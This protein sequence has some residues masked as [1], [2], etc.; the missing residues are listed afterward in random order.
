MHRRR[1]ELVDNALEFF[2]SNGKTVFLSFTDPKVDDIGLSLWQ[3]IF[4]AKE[5]NIYFN[6]QRSCVLLCPCLGG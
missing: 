4:V 2:L 3:H 5:T 1:Y 6:K